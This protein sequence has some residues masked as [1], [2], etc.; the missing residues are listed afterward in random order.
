MVRLGAERD[1]LGVVV[2]QIGTPT[3]AGDLAVAVM[4]IIKQNNKPV[5]EV[6]HFSNEGAISWYDFAKT[7]MNNKNISCQVDPIDSR[8][9][10][11]KANRP[12]YS[13]LNKSKIKRDLGIEIPYWFES[14]KKVLKEL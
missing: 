1:K 13:V 12:Y 9:F 6:Y 10:P 8:E 4:E 14:L 11:A 5:K 7:I 2:D 3:Y